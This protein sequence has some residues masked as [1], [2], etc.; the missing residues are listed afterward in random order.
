MTAG[1]NTG[2]LRHMIERPPDAECWTWTGVLDKDG[3]GRSTGNLAHRLVFKKRGGVIPE[4]YTLDHLCRNRACVNPAHLE[5][6]TMRENTLRGKTVSA[7]HAQK[8]HCIH[9]HELTAENIYRKGR[10]RICRT[11]NLAGQKA[12]RDRK[13]EQN[14]GE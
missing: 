1:R 12:R 10:K 11:C 5:P 9:G 8:T 4:G 3:Y 2:L 13:R 6:V 7:A 14:D